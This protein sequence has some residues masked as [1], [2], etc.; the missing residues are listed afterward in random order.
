MVSVTLGS[1]VAQASWPA[2]LVCT[3][4]GLKVSIQLPAQ[5]NPQGISMGGSL[6]VNG[7]SAPAMVT[8]YSPL[9]LKIM[10]QS[11]YACVLA[12]KGSIVGECG[13]VASGQE[14]QVTC[15]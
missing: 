14:T 5:I 12:I 3:A 6:S 11:G 10:N 8:D 1:L 7:Q 9:E 15:Q 13:L 4:D 2:N